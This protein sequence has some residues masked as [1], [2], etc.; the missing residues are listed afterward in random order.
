M[1]KLVIY[2][3]PYTKQCIIGPLCKLTEAILE[4][5]LP[6]MM[7]FV[8]NNG[9]ETNNR[10]L[11][12]S[13]GVLMIGMVF[14]GF[15]FSMV[16]QYQAAIA[17]QG[18]GTN[19]R[20]A[21]MKQITQFSYKDIDAFTTS[22][23]SNRLIN[24]VNQLQIGVA[25]MIRLVIRSPFII[26]GAIIMSMMLDVTLSLILISTIPFI[27]LI[28]FLFIRYSSPLYQSYQD[29]LD[30]YATILGDNFSG[31]RVIRSFVAQ[32]AQQK[33]VHTQVDDLQRQMLRVSR[34]SALLNPLTALVINASIILLLWSGLI[35]I[36]AGNISSGT[37]IACIN[38]AT[39]I[40][41]ALVATS[42]L[43]VIFT[44]ASAS[45]KRVEEVLTHTPSMKEGSKT[46]AQYGSV[47]LS[48][49]QVSFGYN[50]KEECLHNIS[51]DIKKGESIG[52]IGGTG[53]GK[54]T[55]VHLIARFYDS[56]HG[57]ITIF[58]TPIQ[59]LTYDCLRN[60]ISIVSQKSELFS[61]TIEHNL[62]M[63]CTY[64]KEELYKALED[65]Q[66]LSFVNAL[67]DGIHS[68]IEQDG[69]NLSGGQ[70]QRLCIARSL[71]KQSPILILDDASSALDFRTDAALRQSL[72]DYDMTRI[73]VSQRVG[74][75]L[76]CDH[77]IVLHEGFM[78][79]NGSHHELYDTC[80]TYQS[81][82]K[83]QQIGRDAI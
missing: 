36:D 32:R 54:S 83:S 31:I 58:D 75:L 78:V 34:C 60:T 37:I 23:L 56:H 19:L 43:I 16:C 64:R 41:I 67:Q 62:C 39:Q 74:T 33:K 73:Y 70:K 4:L 57:N 51:F 5:L 25:M 1:R 24:D 47:A 77:I 44:K 65:A 53:S 38:Y 61:D 48:F 20:D 28:L 3:K 10:S 81:I 17:S 63:G 69:R 45:A 68:R 40:L 66:A 59:D 6:T 26:I 7:A 27:I 80:P 49:H 50:D 8:I 46:I 42:N 12:L 22:S 21:M 79:G 18:F 30:T 2:L 72:Q 11:V 15:A 82:C 14:I 71:L 13:L 9:I 35:Q 55:L 76:S 29:K 52:V